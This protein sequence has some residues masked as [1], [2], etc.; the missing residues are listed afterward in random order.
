MDRVARR[1]DFSSIAQRK[2]WSR[3]T[4]APRTLKGLE[5]WGQIKCYYNTGTHMRSGNSWEREWEF[6]IGGALEE[7]RVN[8]AIQAIQEAFAPSVQRT[9]QFARGGLT[10][11]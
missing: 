8:E 2:I 3:W 10:P 7:D 6:M 5:G 4:H 9:I 11:T 1:C